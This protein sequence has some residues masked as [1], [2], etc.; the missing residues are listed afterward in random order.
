VWPG[1]AADHSP[2][3]SAAVM[4]ESTHPLGHT[5][6]VTESLY[7]YLYFLSTLY[8]KI[9]LLKYRNYVSCVNLDVFPT[10]FCSRTRFWLRK[11]TA[12]PHVQIESTDDRN[13]KLKLYISK[14]ILDSYKY[15]PEAY[16][17]THCMILPRPL[18]VAFFLGT[19][20]GKG[21]VIPLQSR[22]GPE[23]G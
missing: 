3:S 13:S 23:G 17:I 18:I 20:E 14:L 22:C 12:Y 21:K 19:R 7:L 5:G 1:R 2:P 8:Y 16:V 9:F 6:P 10:L 11:V 15:M 4:E